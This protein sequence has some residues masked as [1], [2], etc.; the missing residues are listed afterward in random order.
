MLRYL[1]VFFC[2]FNITLSSHWTP[3]PLGTFH[4]KDAGFIEVYETHPE[5]EKYS[6]RFSVYLTTFNPSKYEGLSSSFAHWLL[7]NA[8]NGLKSVSKLLRIYWGVF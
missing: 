1:L 3:K 5:A 2:I 7:E 6:D 4:L 8:K